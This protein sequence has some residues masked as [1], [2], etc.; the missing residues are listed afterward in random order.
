MDY[1][2]RERGVS[3]R[4]ILNYKS[5]IVFYWKSQV[6]YEIPEGN[7]VVSD[8]IRSFKRERPIPAK[9]VVEWDIHLVLEFFKSGRFKH[10]DQLSDK[11]LTLR[12]VFLLA[13]ATEKRRSKIHALS[14]EVRWINGDIR[15]VK[16][17]PIPSF[18]RKTHHQWSRGPE[19]NHSQ[20]A[21]RGWSGEE[22]GDHRVRTLES[23]MKRASKY[24]SPEQ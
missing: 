24:R 7:S 4:T 23:N 11:D 2:F 8:L 1:L 6:G 19:T 18:M 13:L 16:I 15:T 5:A 22:N 17:S 3:V 20:L 21:G 10:W 12:T 14:Q 9:N